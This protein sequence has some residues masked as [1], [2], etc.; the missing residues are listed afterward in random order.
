VIK[1]LFKRKELLFLLFFLPIYFL[2]MLNITAESRMLKLVSVI[3]FSFVLIL[4]FFR[5]YQ[6][7]ELLGWIGIGL[8]LSTITICS[9]K[10]GALFTFVMFFAIKGLDYQKLYQYC[11]PIGIAGVLLSMYLEFDGSYNMRFINGTWQMIFKRSNIL[12]I[13]FTSVIGLY[14]LTVR[15]KFRLR[16]LLA[17]SLLSYVMY[18]YSGSRT[19]LVVMCIFV[20]CLLILRIKKIRRLK[21]TELILC[22]TPL[23]CFGASIYMGKFYGQKGYLTY[24][25]SMIQG[26]LA[27]SNTFLNSYEPKLFGQKLAESME[28][29]S[30]MVLD[31]AYVDMFLAYGIIFS[32]VW[33]ILTMK[34]IQYLY[35]R[36]RYVEIALMVMYAFYGITETFLP[37]CFLNTSLFLY[38]EYLYALPHKNGHAASV[39][40][41]CR[42]WKME[43]ITA[44]AHKE[45]QYE[46]YKSNCNVSPAISPDSGK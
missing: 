37:N 33:L 21:I 9:G 3:A 1:M 27:L 45:Y 23:L 2:K 46:K 14:I 17:I 42:G 39:R 11:L 38:A 6:V 41:R 8:L 40:K 15:N 36:D 4:M 24:I 43:G 31:C 13:S 5:K 34:V 35:Q 22:A 7:K 10:A 44:E 18:K 16:N 19:G 25:N 20:L 30:F 32:M 12:F 26:R 29:D 28:A